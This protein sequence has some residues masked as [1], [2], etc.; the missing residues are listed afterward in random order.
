MATSIQILHAVITIDINLDGVVGGMEDGELNAGTYHE[1]IL[2]SSFIKDTEYH[3]RN[4]VNF[5]MSEY[6]WSNSELK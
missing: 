1:K 6:V 4:V 2:L 3:F 5:R